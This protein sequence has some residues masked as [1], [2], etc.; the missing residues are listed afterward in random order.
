MPI[1]RRWIIRWRRGSASRGRTPKYGPPPQDRGAPFGAPY[2]RWHVEKTRRGEK[3]EI[4][5]DMY[6]PLPKNK[7][8]ILKRVAHLVGI[9]HK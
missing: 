3:A 6:K 7:V 5:Y 2:V 1:F 4:R 8:S 9:S